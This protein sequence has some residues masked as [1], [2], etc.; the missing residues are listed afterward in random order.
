MNSNKHKFTLVVVVV[1]IAIVFLIIFPP[2]SET[3]PSSEKVVNKKEREQS[4]QIFLTPDEFISLIQQIEDVRPTE[5]EKREDYFERI[6]ASASLFVEDPFFD[7]YADGA[8][9]RK[10]DGKVECF[11]SGFDKESGYD[12]AKPLQY[13]SFMMIVSDYSEVQHICTELI[14]IFESNSLIDNSIDLQG[15]DFEYFGIVGNDGAEILHIDKFPDG[16]VIRVYYPF[17]T[18]K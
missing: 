16:Y 1:L 4:V 8:D 3:R 15:A 18:E 5:N 7:V 9:F 13:A 12:A 14:S 6:G 17:A 10:D 2:R 11:V